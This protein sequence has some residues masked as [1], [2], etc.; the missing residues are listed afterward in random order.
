M[1]IFLPSSYNSKST[2]RLSFYFIKYYAIS[3]NIKLYVLKLI[4]GEAKNKLLSK[5]F[6]L[7]F[8]LKI[9]KF[10]LICM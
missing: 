6:L 7:I 10:Y 2:S 1:P 9:I 8:L 5:I 3:V 4:S